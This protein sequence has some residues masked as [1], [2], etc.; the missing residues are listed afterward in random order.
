MSLKPDKINELHAQL[1]WISD[2]S[3]GGLA[4]EKPRV[5]ANKPWILWQFSQTAT[6]N[7]GAHDLILDGSIY[8]KDLIALKRDLG[9]KP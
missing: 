2:Y 8:E 3:K 6:A 9:V 5:P 1:I 7:D 4:S